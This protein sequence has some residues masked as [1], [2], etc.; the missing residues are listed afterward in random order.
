ME[1]S[2]T[3]TKKDYWEYNKYTLLHIWPITRIFI[4]TP[5]IVFVI[6]LGAG[7]IF[8]LNMWVCLGL[9]TL[10]PAFYIASIFIPMYRGVMKIPKEQLQ[11]QTLTLDLEKRQLIRRVGGKTD[12]YNEANIYKY[13]RTRNYIFLTMGS[14]A[15]VVIPSSKDYSLD[16]VMQSIEKIF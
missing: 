1:L 4:L 12:K 8:R 7:L 15:S 16:E 13:Y 2:F 10:L 5:A 3:L 14:F 6:A 9:A 11:K